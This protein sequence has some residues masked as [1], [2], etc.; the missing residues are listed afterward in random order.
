MGNNKAPKERYIQQCDAP[1]YCRCALN[2]LKAHVKKGTLVPPIQLNGGLYWK[3]S[4][5]DDLKLHHMRAYTGKRTQ[6]LVRD[7]PPNAIAAS[8]DETAA[9]AEAIGCAKDATLSE[10]QEN[11]KADLSKMAVSNELI[12]TLFTMLQSP[13]ETVKIRAATIILD[14]LLP[15]QKAMQVTTNETTQQMARKE[16]ATRALEILAARMERDKTPNITI[17]LT[18]GE[19]RVIEAP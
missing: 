6:P 5:L 17:P 4:D 14:K 1:K 13:S 11:L 10:V 9:L 12:K 7:L 2:T 8:T 18:A 3:Q 19:Y 15:S 16:R